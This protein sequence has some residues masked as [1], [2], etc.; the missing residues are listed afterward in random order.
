MT[1]RRIG[2]PFGLQPHGSETLKLSS[3]P[4]LIETVRDSVGLY[5][6][7][8][9]HGLVFCVEELYFRQLRNRIDTQSGNVYAPGAPTAHE[10]LSRVTSFRRT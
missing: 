3:D 9:D 6:N 10:R 1:I 5:L 8:P 7:P 2:R 4:L